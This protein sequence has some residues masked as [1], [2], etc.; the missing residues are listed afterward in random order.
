M[1]AIHSVVISSQGEF[2]RAVINAADVDSDRLGFTIR[3]GDLIEPLA[4]A[5]A[6][7]PAITVRRPCR[8]T[9]MRQ[10]PTV[11][12]VDVGN[13][14]PLT[15]PIVINAEGLSG[16]SER[17][18]RQVALVADVEVDAIEEGTAFERF[19]RD[20]PLALLPLRPQQGQ[21]A[22]ARAMAMVWCMPPAEATRRL[23]LADSHFLGELQ[24]AF[25][26]RNGRLLAIGRRGSHALY[27]QARE[28]LRE[29]RIAYLG[30]AAQSLHPVAGQGLNLG[31]RDCAVLADALG[32]ACSR[33]DDPLVA[34]SE[35]ERLRRADRAT[36]VTLTRHAP[37]LFAT[38]FAPVSLGRSFALTALSTMPA[39]RR[40]F[41][42]LLM[43]GVRR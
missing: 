29:H 28:T 15:T 18:A 38:R 21:Q 42:R 12:E 13:D 16:V 34:L 39:L 36:I 5:V 23:A 32:A 7:E 3:Y 40:E 1:T 11:V 25:G 35:Y 17:S 37:Q 30:N 6:R 9:A 27:E 43:F 19:T 41:A 4:A 24:R 10:T 14:P 22:G 26:S 33:G 8:V 2:G 31:L 20:G